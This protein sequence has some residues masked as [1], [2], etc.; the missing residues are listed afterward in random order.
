MKRVDNEQFTHFGQ[1]A[2]DGIFCM[3]KLNC[4]V[5]M[6]YLGELVA[7][8]AMCLCRVYLCWLDETCRYKIYYCVS[9]YIC[10]DLDALLLRSESS[11]MYAHSSIPHI[12]DECRVHLDD[13]SMRCAA[14]MLAFV[15]ACV[16]A[17]IVCGWV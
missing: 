16:H 10:T 13:F 1:N 8:E 4:A 6:T 3:P 12:R 9:F 14:D 17:D 15:R 5:I 2:N 11:V 7:I